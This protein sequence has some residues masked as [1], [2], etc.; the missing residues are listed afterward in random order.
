MTRIAR[1]FDALAREGRSGFAPFMMS[2]D[3]DY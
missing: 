3:P 2:G 1:L